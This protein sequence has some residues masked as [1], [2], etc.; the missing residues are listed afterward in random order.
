M[1]QNKTG[2]RAQTKKDAEQEK[3]NSDTQTIQL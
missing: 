3:D 1:P 2:R